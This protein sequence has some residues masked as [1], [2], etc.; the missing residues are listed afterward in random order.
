MGLV[1]KSI[2]FMYILKKVFDFIIVKIGNCMHSVIITE[3]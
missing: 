3:Y 2:I 1:E